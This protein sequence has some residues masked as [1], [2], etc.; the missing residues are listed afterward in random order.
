MKMKTPAPQS[1]STNILE[2]PFAAAAVAE[3]GWWRAHKYLLLRRL[4]QLSLFGLFALGP[5]AGIWILKGN[6]SASLLLDTVPL[7]DPLVALQVL[8]TG[9]IPE[10]SLLIGAG[11]IAL[12]YGVAGGRVFC[13]W[14]CPVNLVTDTA[15]WLRRRLNLPRTSELP[16]NLRYYLLA[17]VLLLPLITGL[18]VWEWINPVPVLY[19]AILFGTVG[20]LW[21]LVAIFLLDLFIVERA[22]CGHLCPAGALFGLSGKLSP[23]KIAALQAKDCNNCLDCFAVCPERHVLKPALKGQNPVILSQDCTQCGRCI[24]VC[25]KRVFSYQHRFTFANAHSNTQSPTESTLPNIRQ[26]IATKAENDQ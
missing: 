20:S 21:L 18:T 13:S 9:H 17:L 22:W 25:A 19:R 15:S 26:H 14:V 8:M 5:V 10:F 1:K 6:L 4:V 11:I 7:A 24:D 2:T 23:I 3:L 16:R 12:F